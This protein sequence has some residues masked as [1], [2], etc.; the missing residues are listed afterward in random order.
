MADIHQSNQYG[1]L[2]RR[3]GYSVGLE[4]IVERVNKL[5]ELYVKESD[6]NLA[7]WKNLVKEEY[8][9]KI[10]D[11]FEAAKWGGS[12]KTKKK[13]GAEDHFADFYSELNLI[14]HQNN[15]IFPL[16]GLEILSILRRFY[17]DNN[18][19]QEVL[20]SIILLFILEADGDIFLNCL[21][22]NFDKEKV[23]ENLS[24]MFSIKKHVYLSSFISPFSHNKL[25]Q[26]FKVQTSTAQE[27][28]FSPKNP[29]QK[30]DNEIPED[31]L[32]KI[33]PSRKGW[34][35]E[36]D[37]FSNTLNAKGK[38]IIDFL[39]QMNIVNNTQAIFYS[40]S[41]THKS[42][43]LD[44]KNLG[45]HPISRKSF[46]K[47]FFEAY[48][49]NENSNNPLKEVNHQE[50]YNLLFRIMSLYKTGNKTKGILRHQLP[51]QVLY[52]TYYVISILDDLQYGDLDVFIQHEQKSA[53]RKLD[54]IHLR[55]SETEGALSFRL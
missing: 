20:K 33:L 46:I 35:T 55:G 25:S 27:S 23:K 45:I 24:N 28:I 29:N 36:L 37:I 10:S 43:F 39:R 9:R 26:L 14:F 30:N 3:I 44:E 21:L 5:V 8:G 42:L 2:I 50:I 7:L 48:L 54:I 41:E 49:K 1:K 47:N 40:Y 31:Y 12:R 4:D 18:K 19:F 51:L 22:G 38:K 11:D 15:Q 32:S 34:A 52:P 53:D 17:S 13:L 6:I 16:Y